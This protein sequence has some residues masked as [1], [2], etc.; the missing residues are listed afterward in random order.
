MRSETARLGI[1][2][3]RF[4][5]ARIVTRVRSGLPWF[6]THLPLIPVPVR[7]ERPAFAAAAIDHEPLWNQLHPGSRRD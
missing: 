3:L 4:G 1:A 2:K 5:I 6:D 7:S